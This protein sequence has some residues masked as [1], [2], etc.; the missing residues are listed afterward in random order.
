MR[1]KTL[2]LCATVLTGANASAQSSVTLYG[3]ADA[4]V[5]YLNNAVASTGTVP[6]NAVGHNLFALQSG[7]MSGS[8]WGLRGKVD[9][10]GNLQGVF[11][12]ESGFALDS[13]LSSQGGR[14]FGRGAWVGL[15]NSWGQVSLGRQ[16]APIYDF[17]ARLDPMQIIGRYSIAAQDPA[18]GG[19]RA[20]NSIK[21][22]GDFGDL[23]LAG[24]YSFNNNNQE[25]AGNFTNG[26]EHGASAIYSINS[27]SFGVAYQQANRSSAT[28]LT[29]N[30]FIRRIAAGATYDI[31]T[32]TL[33]AGY[34]YAHA[35]NGRILP[36]ARVANTA[37]NL[38]W[39]GVRTEVTP[40]L[41]LVGAAYYQN[42][43][44][45]GS[46]NPWQFS[47]MADY[48]FSKQTNLYML[49]SYALNNGKSTLGVNGFNDQQGASSEAVQPG[50]NQFGVVMGIR[51]KF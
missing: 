40:A 36:G 6:D 21:Y 32:V 22:K 49:V 16:T 13:G 29:T 41:T 30:S 26:R 3:V 44:N 38:A 10:G 7:N 12:L 46:G 28:V 33:Y 39:A 11:L 25:V 34:R 18:I 51:H 27:L 1:L 15:Q 19:S 50:A 14:L 47:G 4:G 2:A 31:G 35:F 37:S 17:G 23:K 8:R 9:L 48:M 45:A 24:L 43:R 20:D 5:E 42:L